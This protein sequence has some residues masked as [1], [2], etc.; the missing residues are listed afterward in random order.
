MLSP[1]HMFRACQVDCG[2][3]GYGRLLGLRGI[4]VMED[5]GLVGLDSC[6]KC[7]LSPTCQAFNVD[8]PFPA[9]TDN[10]RAKAM[11]RATR[12]STCG[13]PRHEKKQTIGFNSVA[14]LHQKR[15][16]KRAREKGR[17]DQAL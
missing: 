5:F 15:N 4:G 10:Q 8:L 17:E 2:V 3:N 7:M 11:R 9:C 14:T 16:N 1:S 6:I 13:K 12:S